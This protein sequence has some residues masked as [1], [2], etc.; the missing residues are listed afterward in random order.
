MTNS[1][2]FQRVTSAWCIH[3]ILLQH[4][5]DKHQNLAS[6]PGWLCESQSCLW[7]KHLA[8]HLPQ[9]R[10]YTLLWTE[11]QVNF[12]ALQRLVCTCWHGEAELC[13]DTALVTSCL[14]S[15]PFQTGE[16]KHNNDSTA[17]LY[18]VLFSGTRSCAVL[19]WFLVQATSTTIQ[20]HQTQICDSAEYVSD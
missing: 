6:L 2:S 17:I 7:D 10:N 12:Q 5:S 3:C 13:I 11:V 20:Y 19:W 18:A 4:V 16:T 15:C 9:A 8:V 1:R 14:R